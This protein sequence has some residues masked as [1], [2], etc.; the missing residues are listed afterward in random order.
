MDDKDQIENL[1][2]S[3]VS[4]EEVDAVLDDAQRKIMDER[5]ERFW[6]EIEE[7]MNSPKEKFREFFH[8]IILPILYGILF[9]LILTQVIFFHANVPTGSMETTIMTGDRILGS[10]VAYWFNDPDYGDIIIFWSEE[11]GEFMVKRVIGRPGDLVE[12]RSEG[13]FVNDKLIS[14]EY[15]QGETRRLH[16]GESSWLVPEESYFV[17]G[18]NRETSA[19]SRYWVNTYVP[20]EEIYARYM[21]RYSLGKNGWYLDWND[22]IEFW[23]EP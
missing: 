23:A 4:E 13:V 14:D 9:A 12:I 11:Y 19:D 22:K 21:F 15:T 16:A 1:A 10:R 7:E 8:S 2:P 20:R 17:M 18:D 5:F 3:D 6:Q